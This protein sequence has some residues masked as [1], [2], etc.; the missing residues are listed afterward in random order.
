MSA[1]VF[2]VCI[3]LL[4]F[5]CIYL[6]N[7]GTWNIWVN[8]YTILYLCPACAA[9]VWSISCSLAPRLSCCFNK[10][11]IINKQVAGGGETLPLLARS[12][13]QSMTIILC[14][15]CTSKYTKDRFHTLAVGAT[16]FS[17]FIRCL[18]EIYIWNWGYRA[19]DACDTY[20]TY[21]INVM[22]IVV[23]VFSFVQIACLVLRA[24]YFFFFSWYR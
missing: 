8:Q 6:Y 17:L 24:I 19:R 11:V 7:N 22:L 20:R 12:H 13:S 16:L 3:L 5:V 23:L 15:A 1:H 14:C 2:F 9:A 4:F 18:F 10:I 21:Y